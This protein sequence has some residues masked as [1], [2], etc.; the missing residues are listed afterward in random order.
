MEPR[1]TSVQDIP[2]DPRLFHRW[3]NAEACWTAWPSELMAMAIRAGWALTYR[4][5]D[6]WLTNLDKRRTAKGYW[7]AF[8]T[9]YAEWEARS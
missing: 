8:T 5:D 2:T 9:A 7:S 6:D 3:L 4:L 1:S